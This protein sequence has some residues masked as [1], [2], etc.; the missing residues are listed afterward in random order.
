MFKLI[1]RKTYLIRVY[2]T[3]RLPSGYNARWNAQ[4]GCYEIASTSRDRAVVQGSMNA[5]VQKYY[6]LPRRPDEEDYQRV[7]NCYIVEYVKIVSLQTGRIGFE[8]LESYRDCEIKSFFSYGEWQLDLIE[9]QEDYAKF[10]VMTDTGL[11]EKLQDLANR[12]NCTD[13]EWI[14]PTTISAPVTETPTSE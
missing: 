1:K 10:N 2:C 8:M 13:V 11:C 12:A 9:V 7:I 6:A 5:L 14:V 4:R 3:G